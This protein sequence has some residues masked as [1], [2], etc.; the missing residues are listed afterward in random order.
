MTGNLTHT[1]L[2]WLLRIQQ[3]P[4]DAA[5]R[6]ELAAW[7][8]ID[9]RHVEAYRQAERVWQ[10]TGL[11]EAAATPPPAETPRIPA[12]PIAAAA[13][14]AIRPQRLRRRRWP[15]LLAGSLAACFIL[16]VAPDAYLGYQSDYRT[17]LGEQRSIELD[18]GSRVQLD[19]QSAISV[20][21]DSSRREVR[22]L[23]GQA[24]FEVTPDQS[25]P[26]RV[27]ANNLQITVTGTAFNVAVRASQLTVAV[28]HG[29][30]R[31]A[32][33]NHTLAEALHAGDRLQWRSSDQVTRDKLP[34]SQIAVWQQ[35]RLVVRDAR[36]ADVLDELRPYLPGKLAL[37]DDRL[38]AKRITGVYDLR[39]PDAALR[40][41]LQP[42]QGQVSTWTPWLRV[43]ERQP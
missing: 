40:A 24:F 8:A 25:R 30:V 29:S 39:D 33:G 9:T 26:F 37:R 27:D 41:I 13:V 11:N 4:E 18:D 42:Y 31:V 38:G 32:E 17:D 5:L 21:F 28:Q 6:T 1:A 19:S 3:R 20:E 10:L 36:I 23:S 22:L 2:D 7:L 43:V 34:L 12:A 16:W 15:A 35:G 14:P